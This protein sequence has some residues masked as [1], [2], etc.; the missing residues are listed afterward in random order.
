MSLTTSF[1]PLSAI[2]DEW[3]TYSVIVS[4]W[5]DQWIFCRQKTRDT[6]EL[7]AGRREP[8]ESIQQTAWRELQEETG[9]QRFTIEPI[10]AIHVADAGARPGPSSPCGFLCYAEIAEL[11]DLREDVEIAEIIFCHG[12]PQPLSY[13]AVQPLLFDVG[14]CH[15][16]GNLDRAALFANQFDP[17][18]CLSDG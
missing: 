17:G 9:A 18:R 10:C 4:R 5:Q 3:L 8:G 2:D 15:A 12:L 7:P 16:A 13:P 14:R 6:Y 11:G 1:Y